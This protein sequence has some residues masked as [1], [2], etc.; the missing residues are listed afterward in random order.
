MAKRTEVLSAE[1]AEALYEAAEFARKNSWH[2][3][4]LGE[5]L[6]LLNSAVRK[7]RRAETLHIQEEEIDNA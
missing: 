1:E 5:R 4:H 7:L 6:A 2:I 3:N